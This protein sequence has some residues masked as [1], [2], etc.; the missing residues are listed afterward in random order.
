M[1]NAEDF[2]SDNAID[3]GERP[4]GEVMSLPTAIPVSGVDIGQCVKGALT[5]LGAS[6]NIGEFMNTD[7]SKLHLLEDHNGGA[8]GGDVLLPSFSEIRY[9][10]DK[11]VP[12]ASAFDDFRRGRKEL[13]DFS[14][15]NDEESVGTNGES[16]CD[17]DGYDGGAV[18][19]VDDHVGETD[20]GVERDGP[21]AE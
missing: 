11:S 6:S 9:C 20:G 16:I 10:A 8:V 3:I 17:G 18:E 7:W 2:F 5:S 13:C 21:Q 19:T 4:L 14:A 12:F 15:D 1:P